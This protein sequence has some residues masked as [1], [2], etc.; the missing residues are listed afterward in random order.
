MTP[1]L[2]S[3]KE[4]GWPRSHEESNSTLV[5]HVSPTYWTVTLSPFLAAGPLPLTMSTLWSVSGG[6][7]SG[8]VT[9]GFFVTLVLS[10]VA[11]GFG[12][13]VPAASDSL[14]PPLPQ[15]GRASAHASRMWIVRCL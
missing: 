6:S 12:V 15:P 7:S 14:P 9:V 1:P 11:V 4:N 10:G 13:A 8:T 5:L 3:G 2:P